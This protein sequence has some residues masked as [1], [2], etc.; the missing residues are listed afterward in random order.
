[1]ETRY[2]KGGV[3]IRSTLITSIFMLMLTYCII[4]FAGGYQYSNHIAMN[5]TLA[6]TYNAVNAAGSSPYSGA[7]GLFSLTALNNYQNS[8]HTN[9]GTWSGVLNIAV[10][11]MV[12]AMNFAFTIPISIYALMNFIAAPIAMIIPV[13]TG[14]IVAGL[15]L[16]LASIIILTIISSLLIY[17]T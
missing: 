9:L 15:T 2:L 3:P 17:P 13:G 10:S 11:S 5:G 7:S 12:M 14:Y 4:G 1:M 8:T 16:L 6:A